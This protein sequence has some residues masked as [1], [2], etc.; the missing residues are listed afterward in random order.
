MVKNFFTV[1]D[2]GVSAKQL[3]ESTSEKRARELMEATTKRTNSGRF[4]TGLLWKHDKVEFPDSRAMAEKRLQFLEKRLSKEPKLY[5]NVRKQIADYLAKGY[6]HKATELEL[7]ETKASDVWYLPLGVVTNPKKPEKLRIVW[8]AAA[9]VKGVSLNSVLLKGP[10]LLQSL[11]TVLCRFRQKEVAINADIKEMFHQV[12]IRSEDRQALRFLWRNQPSE[13]VQVFV[14]NVAIFG[15]TC[16][17]CS[18]QF[19]KNL[20]AS[21][22]STEFPRAATAVIE[23]HYVDDYLDSVDTA[24]EAVQLAD[25]VKTIH[26]RGGFELRHWLSN[27]PEVLERIGEESSESSKNFVM[28]KCTNSERILGMILIPQEDIF[29]FAVQFRSDLK[30]LVDGNGYPTKRELLSLVMSIF[31]PLGLVANF[32]IHGKVLVQ[33]VWRSGIEWDETIPEAIYPMWNRWILALQEL[34]SVRINRSYFPGY[35]PKSLESIELHVFVDA[36]MT[37]YA[38]AAYFRIIDRETV[39]CTLVAS[40]TKVAPLKQLSVP[41][42]EL[43]AD[44]IGTRLMKTII[45][46]HTIPIRRKIFWSDSNIVL[47]WLRS[48][49]HQFHQFVAFRVGEIL[50]QS[51]A[52]DWRKVPTRWNVSDEA[53]KWGNGPVAAETCRWQRGPE[54]LYK[55]ERDWPE[56]EKNWVTS[57]EMRIV[58]L[59]HRTGTE[60]IF[61]FERFS[62]WER[63]LRT[64]AYVRRFR[65]NC[66][67]KKNELTLPD[68]EILNREELLEAELT[69]V[70]LIQRESFANEYATLVFNQ[71][72]PMEQRK[73]IDKN[74]KLYKLCPFLG[75]D[76]VIRKDGRIGAAPWLSYE[77]KFPAILPK[78]HYVT[79]LIIHSYHRKFGHANNETVVNEL[80]QRFHVSEIRSAVR[81]M[82]DNCRKCK[83]RK[84]SPHPPRMGPLPESRLN[85]Y[86]RPF[87]FTGLDYFGPISI[88]LGRSCVK[89]WVA[90]FTCLTTRVIHLELAFTLATESCKLAV[91]RFIARRGA[92]LEIY[93]DQGTNFQGARKE[94][95]QEINKLNHELAATFTN[96]ATQW[97]LNPPYAPHMGGIWERLV[98][99][100]K[101]A[102][103]AMEM[104]KN[105]DEETLI[106]ALAEAESLI[107]SRPL[108]YLPLDSEENE[109]LTPNHFLLLSS[110]GVCQPVTMQSHNTSAIR[111]NWKHVQVM[112]DRFWSRWIKE[113][114]PVISRQSKWFGEVKSI[115]IGDLVMIVNEMRRNSWERGRVVKLYPGKDGRIRSADVK[116]STGIVQKPLTKLAVLDVLDAESMAE[117]TS[118]NTG[119]GMCATVQNPSST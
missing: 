119:G 31:D 38:A 70:R 95:Q 88:R 40:K 55:N 105:P 78:N 20:N 18:A 44:V 19:V 22:H 63:L 60:E 36:S 39:R 107:N 34:S 13:A 92:P 28:G 109:A 47:A 94:L 26:E 4:Q 14:M 116:T 45:E 16:S 97:K 73:L 85:P 49:Q 83:V 10:D 32:V 93:S 76:G 118:S 6:A 43:Q 48:D 108:T 35:D 33:D 29:S 87:T 58:N 59:H 52:S 77:A 80:R 12:L 106:T 37:A 53:T 89:R 9:S 46:S 117:K 75:G 84:A 79:T 56:Q 104:S 21:E 17:P 103:A 24:E 62:K 8:D 5:E 90:L 110:N 25:E 1:E 91:R 30:K 102:L 69:V 54:S 96:A 57:E 2:T 27:A 82:S 111:S 98:R 51:E 42:L 114:L 86:V 99:S 68:P 61:K 81:K 112:L 66:Q 15:S 64:A 71:Q 101:A 115:H 11:P 3:V 113:F 41:G 67:K 50:E 100:V 23:N 72:V 7:K 74:S 65:Y